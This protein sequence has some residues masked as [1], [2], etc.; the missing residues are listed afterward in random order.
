MI[1]TAACFAAP[2]DVIEPCGFPF[3]TKA[4]RRAAM[5]YVDLT[6]VTHHRSWTAFQAGRSPGR[7][8]ALTTRA[9]CDLFS[10]VFKANDCLLV[11]QE[12]AGLPEHVHEAAEA[13]V[14]IPMPGGGRSLNVGVAAAIALAEAYRQ[15]LGRC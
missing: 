10:F 7:L 2:L 15:S 8:V 9:E 5:D 6:E 14:S 1:R 4:L 13:R 11:G 12:S 3:S